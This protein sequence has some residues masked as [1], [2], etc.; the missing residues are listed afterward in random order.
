MW[1][2]QVRQSRWRLRRD[3]SSSQ[4]SGG[5]GGTDVRRTADVFASRRKGNGAA[6][7]K[8]ANIRRGLVGG[9]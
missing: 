4:S 9:V 2:R 6:R 8:S 1:K 7:P 3:G 5:G